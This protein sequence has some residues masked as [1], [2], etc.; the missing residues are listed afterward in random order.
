MEQTDKIK[1]CSTCKNR[2]FNP[3]CGTVCSFTK[4]KPSFDDKCDKYV[5]DEVQLSKEASKAEA[6]EEEKSISGWLAFFLWVGVGLGALISAIMGVAQTF[7]QGF[8]WLFSSTYLIMIVSLLVIAT[9]TIIAFYKRKSNAVSLA[10][11]Y[12]AMIV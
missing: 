1:L 8:G 11:T 3:E 12:I 7:G 4:E 9:L 6:L 5:A 2:E 10:T